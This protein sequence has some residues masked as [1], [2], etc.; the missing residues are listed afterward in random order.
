ME[1]YRRRSRREGTEDFDLAERAM[2]RDMLTIYKSKYSRTNLASTGGTYLPHS[3]A[4][5]YSAGPQACQAALERGAIRLGQSSR[6]LIPRGGVQVCAAEAFIGLLG[7]ACRARGQ[8]WCSQC[9]YVAPLFP[10][11]AVRSMSL[12]GFQAPVPRSS[13]GTSGSIK[14]SKDLQYLY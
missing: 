12:R 3:E 4:L 9:S 11:V 1:G 5:M 13:C 10:G 7:A 14:L 8:A 6:R 2:L